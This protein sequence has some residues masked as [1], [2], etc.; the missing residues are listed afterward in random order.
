MPRPR[1]FARNLIV[2]GGGAAGLMAARTA[3]RLGA[4]VSLFEREAMGGECLHRGC[5]PSKA[6]I[7]A[8]AEGADF[9]AALAAARRAIAAI[10][11][12]DGT[13]RYRGFGVDVREEEAR[14]LDPWTVAGA[15][16]DIL[17]ARAFVIATGGEPVRPALPGLEGAPVST[18]A[19][20]WDLSA[21]PRRLIVL[22]GG[23]AGIELG[24]AF[25]RLGSSVSLIERA[26]RLLPGM[27]EEAATLITEACR[28][29]GMTVFTAARAERITREGGMFFLHL[30]TGEAGTERRLSFDH[31]LLASGKRP[32][33]QGLEALGLTLTP[34]GHI[35]TDRHLRTSLPHV[36]AAGDVTAEGGATPVAG[37]HGVYAALNALLGPLGRLSPPRH[38]RPA[39]L[40]TTP[41]LARTGLDS[42]AAAAAG[43]EY[44]VLRLDL[45]EL[46]R[47]VIAEMLGEGGGAG[48]V[49]LILRR[50]DGRILGALAVGG[51]AVEMIGGMA[52]AVHHR[53]TFRHLIP[54]LHPYPGWSEA[55]TRAAA[56]WRLARLPPHLRHWGERFFRWRRGARED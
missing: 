48:F 18:T 19:T 12:R 1:R 13:E 3:A 56:E 52:V 11:P 42:A 10:A 53:L 15:G 51:A 20:I 43:I 29:L 17:T 33:L 2:V 31:L 8:I 9:A 41:P 49:K 45:S 54:V 27:D 38:A 16:G 26:P 39:V 5:V 22:G 28:R 7:G 6:F 36:F 37:Q 32:R 30:R 50:R 24:Q 40:F 44:E 55:F 35:R 47:A 34:S 25:A 21:L 4:A 23:A 46:D 14:F